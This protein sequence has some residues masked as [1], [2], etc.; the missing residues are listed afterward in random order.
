[1]TQ[2]SVIKTAIFTKAEIPQR[3]GALGVICPLR[4]DHSAFTCS[5]DLVGVETERAQISDSS[6]FLP[7]VFSPMRF[8]G[9]FYDEESVFARQVTERGH[10][11]GMTVSMNRHYC[12]SVGSNFRLDLA[13]IQAPRA[14]VTVNQHRGGAGLDNGEGARDDGERGHD[15]F[16]ARPNSETRH[17]NLQRRRPITDGN[18]M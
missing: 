14:R 1:M 2:F 11:Y 3:T 17:G 7:F 12:T 8:S 6:N 13:G 18:P 15:D 5:N 4:Q 9:V 10:V 16:I